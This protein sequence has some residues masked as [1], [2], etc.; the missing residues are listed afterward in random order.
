MAYYEG[1]LVTKENRPN[2]A[3]IGAEI[4]ADKIGSQVYFPS[5]TA[6]RLDEGIPF[7]FS[8]TNDPELFY[9]AALTGHDEPNMPELDLHDLEEKGERYLYPSKASKTY[10]CEVKRTEVIKETDQYGEAKIKLIEGKI[11]EKKGE[12]EYIG[13][14]NPLV[15]A[16]VHASRIFVADGKQ[17]E[18]IRKKVNSILAETESDLKQK[19]LDSVER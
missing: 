16:M 12:G 3:A 2:A 18:N 4:D 9:R 10:F 13:R 17:K 6:R 1:I 5:D 14:E 19:I 15:D 7:T 8:L 11:L